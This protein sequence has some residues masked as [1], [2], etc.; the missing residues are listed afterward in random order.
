MFPSSNLINMYLIYLLIIYFF[1]N[2]LKYIVFNY[3]QL[4]Y[5][6]LNNYI[7]F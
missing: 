1:L 4:Y 5:N 6:I 2:V 3:I 7:V